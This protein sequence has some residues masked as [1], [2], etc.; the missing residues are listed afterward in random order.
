[1]QDNNNIILLKVI[2]KYNM[3]IQP[4]LYKIAVQTER[5]V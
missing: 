2:S 4:K 1:M 5:E 3:P